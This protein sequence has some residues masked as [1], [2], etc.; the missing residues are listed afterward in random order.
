M[1]IHKKILPALAGPWGT[2]AAFA[3]DRYDK[4][5]ARSREDNKIQRTVAD[6]RAAG[7]HPLFALGSAA[8]QSSSG[9]TGSGAGDAIRDIR[10]LA[11]DKARGTRQGG[12]DRTAKAE[13]EARARLD[14]ARASEIEQQLENSKNARLAQ[15]S[16]YRQDTL[17][18]PREAVRTFP[19]E[20]Q[21]FVG[22]PKP[23]MSVGPGGIRKRNPMYSTAQ[24]NEDL[25][26]EFVGEFY[27]ILN[28]LDA[29]FRNMGDVGRRRR[30]AQKKRYTVK[31]IQRNYA[32]G[33]TP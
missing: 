2:A 7:I 25:H 17:K 31:P 18:T 6:A 13:S 24:E 5:R 21:G 27:T 3:L 1:P 26:G 32:Y 20:S 22:P 8:G 30:R 16:N 12:L 4:K 29:M 15:E 9:S 14:N 28:E 33:S 10:R 23:F 19:L 11:K